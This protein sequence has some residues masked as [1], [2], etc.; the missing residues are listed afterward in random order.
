MSYI[1]ELVEFVPAFL[2]KYAGKEVDLDK[3]IDNQLE[4][5]R[6]RPKR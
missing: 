4:K 5:N 3:E 1:C 2:N 6:D